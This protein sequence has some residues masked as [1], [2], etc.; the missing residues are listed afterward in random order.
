V[1][2]DAD[3]G[4]IETMRRFGV[5][6]YYGDPSRPELLEAA[7]LSEARVLVVT[8]DDPVKAV[9]IVRFARGRRARPGPCL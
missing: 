8:V 3:P 4:M 5:K 2:L 9:Q 6:G 1:V 7:G